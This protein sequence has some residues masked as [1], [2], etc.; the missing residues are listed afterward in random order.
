MHASSRP[1]GASIAASM[2]VVPG[3]GPATGR[4][5]GSAGTTP[6]A[7]DDH[8]RIAQNITEVTD[9]VVCR[10]YSTGLHAPALVAGPHAC[11]R[12]ARGGPGPTE[13]A[14]R[15][16]NA[17]I[18]AAAPCKIA[19]SSPAP[20]GPRGGRHDPASLSSVACSPAGISVMSASRAGTACC[21]GRWPPTAASAQRNHRASPGPGNAP[22]PG[23]THRGQNP[24]GL[25]GPRQ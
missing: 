16:R 22:L 20:R 15:L 12:P 8:D 18:V 24:G 10:L 19:R 4:A 11:W 6:P 5:A 23:W 13:S 9:V 14:T 1:G 3:S 17:R 2:M 21:R 25:P 7:A